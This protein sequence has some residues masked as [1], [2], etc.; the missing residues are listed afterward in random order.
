MNFSLLRMLRSILIIAK[1]S[2]YSPRGAR[3]GLIIAL[4]TICMWMGW[5]M[6]WVMSSQAQAKTQLQIQ[7]TP[8]T[9]KA[10]EC[11]KESYI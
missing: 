3:Q 5:A 6:G 10:C 2:F 4:A 7:T 8:A 1:V 9:Y 11:K